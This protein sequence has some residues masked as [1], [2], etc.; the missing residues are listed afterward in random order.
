MNR[1][2]KLQQNLSQHNLDGLLVSH[3]ENRRYI[4][5]FTGSAGWLLISENTAFLAVDFRYV[6]QANREAPHFD[7]IHIKGGLSNWL[8]KLASD[9]GL[10]R[11][12]FEADHLP[13]GTYQH[14]HRTMTDGH[15]QSR[16]I[17]TKGLIEALRAVKEPE[18][19][20]SITEAVAL[21][22]A[23]L[24]C[25]RSLICPG[26]SEKDIAWELEKHLRERG[27]EIMPFEIIVASGPN[28]ALPHAQPSERVMRAGEPVLIDLG[29]RVNGYCSDLS[30]TFILGE[31]DKTFSRIYDIVLGAQLTAMSL[32]GAGMSGGQADQLARSVIEE[33]GYGDAFGH[34]LGHGVGLEVHELPR[35]GSASVDSLTNGMVF[36]VEPGIYLTGWG[37][38]RIEDTVVMEKDKVRTLAN[39]EKIPAIY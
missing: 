37:G 7:V 18:E 36:T 16:L 32:I 8:S 22:D 5:G 29:A 3:P 31:G 28:A 12:G 4:S 23:A 1:L 25:A 2:G 6:E 14:L 9:T 30:R 26:A 39:A 19:L 34:G 15:R 33:A 21:A 38:V 11:V 27:S 24:D 20:K 35:L 13:F 10:K 17:A